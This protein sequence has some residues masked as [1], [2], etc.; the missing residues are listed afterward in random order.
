[1]AMPAARDFPCCFCLAPKDN[2]DETRTARPRKRIRLAQCHRRDDGKTTACA[3]SEIPHLKVNAR[4]FPAAL[5]AAAVHLS[6]PEP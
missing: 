3:V 4:E 5:L 2:H 1:M 6:V